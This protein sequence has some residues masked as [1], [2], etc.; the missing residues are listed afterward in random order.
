MTRAPFWLDDRPKKI[1]PRYCAALNPDGT[2]CRRKAEFLPRIGG[3]SADQ[4]VWTP[5]TAITLTLELPV[6]GR[7]KRRYSMVE[8]YIQPRNWRVVVD[9]ARMAGRPVPERHTLF[10]EFVS[11]D[12]LDR[13]RAM[14]TH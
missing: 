9:Y 13:I 10:V 4:A 8:A 7:C 12:H 14:H 1:D 5:D 11:I 2:R 3:W 6:C